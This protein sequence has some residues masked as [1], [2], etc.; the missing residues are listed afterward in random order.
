VRFTAQRLLVEQ[1]KPDEAAKV[2][3]QLL[4]VE[5]DSGEKCRLLAQLHPRAVQA[6]D[7]ETVK[8][9]QTKCAAKP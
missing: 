7:P 4:T 2:A 3:G 1:G 6:L 9:L 8:P 5:K